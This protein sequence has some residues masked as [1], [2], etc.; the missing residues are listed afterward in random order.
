VGRATNP[1]A[2]RLVVEAQALIDRLNG[3]ALE[4]AVELLTRAIAMD[5][6]FAE[7][8]VR[9]GRAYATQSGYGWAPIADG[10]ARARRLAAE[11]LALAPD[12]PDAHILLA[13]IAFSHDFDHA[14]GRASV[15]RA[16]ELAP[17]HAE[18]LRV[19]GMSARNTEE[20]RLALP[21]LER[22]VSLDPLSSGLWGAL[23]HTLRMLGRPEEA[24][25]HFRKALELAPDRVGTRSII[26]ICC[27]EMGR[28]AEAMRELEGESA[29]W[30]FL[31][32]R[33]AVHWRAGRR[34]ESDADLAELKRDHGENC[35]YQIAAIHAVR[36]EADAVFEWLDRAASIR[37]AGVRFAL[38]DPVFAP[39]HG[40]SRWALFRPKVGG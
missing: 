37:D 24:I 30:A 34:A 12:L 8:R 10:Y 29:R 4:R 2:W 33:A 13:Y 39:Y 36:G 1:E 25:V 27:F 17:N 15:A 5:P 23:G 32:A 18:A 26:A 40:D 20:V 9:L 16:L 22:A 28:L 35:A 14:A 21:N 7:A 11:A 6:A 38:I 31:T 3:P 19:S